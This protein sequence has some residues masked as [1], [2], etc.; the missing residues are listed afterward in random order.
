MVIRS[1]LDGCRIIGVVTRGRNW[2]EISG[3]IDIRGCSDGW[4]VEVV[5]DQRAAIG[6]TLLRFQ[7]TAAGTVQLQGNDTILVTGSLPS[8]LAA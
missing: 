1:D 2:S 8:I 6:S 4:L 5:R 7:I 3:Q